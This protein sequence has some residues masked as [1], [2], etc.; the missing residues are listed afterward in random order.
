MMAY[1]RS[2][3][4]RI[5]FVVGNSIFRF[6]IFWKI[7]I[8]FIALNMSPTFKQFLQAETDKA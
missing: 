6:K 3:N 7:V 4:N 8:S 2:L 5:S 1:S